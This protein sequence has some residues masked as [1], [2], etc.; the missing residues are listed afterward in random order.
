MPERPE[1]LSTATPTPL[2]LWGFLVLAA[3]ALLAGLGAVMD[4]AIVGFPDDP[5]G[6]LDVAIKG[7]DV[8]EGTIVLAAAVLALVGQIALRATR[9]R[10]RRRAVA[11]GLASL[12]ALILAIALSVAVRAD[13]RFGGSEGLDELAAGLAEQLDEP[14]DAVRAQ[15]EE[16]FAEQITV[17]LGPGVWVAA[18]GGVLVDLGGA[19]N[20]A[21]V[22]AQPADPGPGAGSPDPV[23]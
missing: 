22:R 10:E 14:V 18:L 8:W 21:W 17:D 6:H 19:L 7:V 15:L 5:S 9:G 11:F 3:G 2:R 13:A 12:G 4:W 1:L 16:R 20:L 23:G